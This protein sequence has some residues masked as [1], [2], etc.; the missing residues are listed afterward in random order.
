MNPLLQPFTG[1]LG[2]PVFSL[3]RPEHFEPAFE[4]AM[5]AHRAELDAIANDAEP[6]TFANTIACFDRSGRWLSRLQ[7]V[8][9]TLTSSDT[10]DELQA[11]QRRMAGPLAAHDNGVHLHAGLFARLHELH[12]RRHQLGLDAASVRLVERLHLDFVRDGALLIGADRDRF[13]LIQ[14]R[15]AQLNTAFAQNVLHDES[16]YQLP[17]PDEASMAGLPEGV[18]AAAAQA[19]VDRGLTGGQR[20]VTLGRSMVLPFLTFSTR[21]DLRETLWR[22]WVSRGEHAG[23]HDNRPLVAE[24][25]QLRQELAALLGHTTY[26]QHALTDRMAGRPEAVQSLV[27]EIWPKALHALA[28]ERQALL[29]AMA[30]QGVGETIEA[31]DWRFW[32]EKVRTARY[33]LDDAQLRPYFPLDAVVNAAFDCANRLFGIRFKLR[34]D[35]PVYH[36]DVRAY[37]VLSAAGDRMGIFVQDNFSRPSKRSGAWMSNLRWQSRNA[38]GD[39]RLPVILNNNNFAKAAAGQPTLLSVEDVTTLFHEF[40]HGL[41]GLLSQVDWARQS[42]AQVLWDFVELPSQLMEH[43]AFEP[44]VLRGYAR[45]WQT[46]AVLGDDVIARLKAARHFNQGYDTVRYLASTIVDMAVHSHR[47]PIA[48]DDVTAFE[49]RTLEA[50]GLPHGVGMNHRLVH[51]Q[52]LFSGSG[53]AAGYYVYLWADVLVADGYEAF[54]EAGSPFDAATAGRLFDHIL[55]RGDSVEPNS[56]YVA[57]R[58]RAPT[59]D[60]LLKERGLVVEV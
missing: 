16:T 32:A 24:I 51:F 33:A 57:F 22:A 19:A 25:L 60:A 36:P 1:P 20:V 50:A 10:N 37:E 28:S 38:E 6:P 11:I 42:G 27:D 26:A 48:A 31:W 35:L 45:H 58:G 13:A 17:L 3:I 18:R 21:R 12:Q 53:Y 40:G 7:Q 49:Q 30:A 5:T 59:V 43:W 46:G 9:E 4:A 44:E 41:H 14:Q 34:T 15:L 55:S 2:L 39:E 29:G 54:V 23:N 56:A 47:E 52:H 8:F